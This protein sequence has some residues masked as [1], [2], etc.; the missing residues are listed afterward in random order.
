MSKNMLFSPMNIGHLQIKNRVV[1][2][3]M[4][5]GF[6]TFDGT[7]TQGLL[8]YYEERAKGGT[9]LII[10]EI[11]RVNDV[12]GASSFN[13]LGASHDYQIPS[14]NE[15]AKRVHRHGA[16]I[17]VQLH[18]PGR[19]NLG[20]MIVT[21]PL[22]IG[23]D[24]CFS[25]YSKL[26]FNNVVPIGK[27]L[28][29]K[30]IVPPVVSPSKCERSYFSDCSNR[31]LTNKGVKKLVSQFISGAVRCKKAGIDG[32][33]L[34]AAHGYLIQQFLSPNTNHRNDEYG[35]T[36]QNRMRF[37]LEIISGIRRECGSEFPIVVRLSV[38][39]CYE[40]IGKPGKGYSLNEGIEMAKILEKAGI[41]AIDVSS[42][43]YD[44][45]NYWLEP[46]TFDCG[47]RKYMAKAVKKQLSIPV[48]AANLI[49]SGD[50]AEQQLQ[51]GYQDFV[52]VGR[53]TI[54]DPHWAKKIEQG[55]EEDVKRCVCCLYCF[56]SMQANAYKGIHANCAVNPMLGHEREGLICNG[57]GKTV[58]IVGAGV[59]GL[60][61]AEILA[62][63]GFKVVMFEKDSAPGGQVV[64][65]SYPPH[66]EK[67]RWCVDD[68]ATATGKLGVEI[69]YNTTATIDLLKELDPYA[70]VVATGAVAVRPM[71]IKGADKSN[72]YTVTEILDGSVKLNGKEVAVVG[73][74]MTGLETAE[75]LALQGNHLS[76]VEM[77]DS[78]APGVWMQHV[79]DI[80]PK[81]KGYDTDFFVSTRLVEILDD[82]ILVENTATKEQRK[83]PCHSVVLSLGSKSNNGIFDIIKNSFDKAYL[84]GDAKNV[85]RIANAT[86]DAYKT[87]ILI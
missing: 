68:L 73:S 33:E 25:F 4:M 2:A 82:G 26:L 72:V 59:A 40:M 60:T 78:I 12:T 19:Q 81:L 52:A 38:D 11:T 55:N 34:H 22:S 29:E 56:E 10:T 62:K 57:S 9:G 8:D 85:G 44:T 54:A 49:R 75:F 1:M 69:R 41:D 76:V 37:L 28:Q 7:A 50:Q 15:L 6:G 3:P 35:G 14:L 17:L 74:G 5:L 58:A 63:R 47:W 24:K 64:L 21:V 83:I 18:H 51:E 48:I 79:D 45:F 43:A 86:G 84:I 23:M 71:S 53:P 61:C 87:A 20:L 32:V 77:A 70:V 66:K 46:V 30:R 65:G 27:K 31:A 80:L 42:G 16:K 36:L 39:E 67:I 13:Q